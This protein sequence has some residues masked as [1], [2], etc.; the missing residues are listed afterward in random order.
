MSLKLRLNVLISVLLGLVL[1]GGAFF[2]MQRAR[3]DVRAEIQ[4]TMNLSELM[5]GA[6]WTGA[7]APE[8]GPV[9]D[10]QAL[11]RVRHLRIE[12]YDAT[13]RLLQTNRRSQAPE[14]AGVP[15]WFARVLTKMT[16][17]WDE[18]RRPLLAGEE[19]I[20]ELVIRPDP[21]YEIEEVW[22]DSVGLV[23][24]ATLLFVGMNFA[25]YGIVGRALRPVDRIL[26]ALT[27]LEQGN[28]KT[29]LP[30]L[31]LPELARIARAFNRMAEALEQSVTQNR[32]LARRLLQVQEEERKSL[33]RELHDELGQYLS[34]IHADAAAILNRDDAALAPVRASAQA[35]VEACRAMMDIVRGML[36]RLRPGALDELGLKEALRELATGWRQRHPA[37]ACALE[38][39]GDLDDLDEA[40]KICI[41]RLVQES[42]TN[43]AKHARAR[44]VEVRL[45]RISGPGSSVRVQVRDDGVGMDP[46]ARQTGFGLAGM[47]ERVE[48]L[49]GRLVVENGRNG[50]LT[51]T[52][53]L[54]LPTDTRV[55]G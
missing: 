41:Y 11:G 47:R 49:G 10:P 9:F 42:L 27:G 45:A 23:Q 40:A 18:V 20:G 38:F 17:A 55:L 15:E 21:S 36:A 26:D 54:P 1:I 39:A 48:S 2:A 16:P 12:L 37:I 30:A 44:R 4:S 5:L 43:V 13:G 8:A 22:K 52:A 6:A 46:S 51:V 50:G 7:S 53:E 19:V 31:D 28:L 24:L 14:A 33:S 34:A 32:R 29:R 35:I 3:E 25:V